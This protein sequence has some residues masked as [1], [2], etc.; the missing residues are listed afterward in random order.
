MVGETLCWFLGGGFSLFIP[1]LATVFTVS[2][3]NMCQVLPLLFYLF[4]CLYLCDDSGPA[5]VAFHYGYR[6]IKPELFGDGIL[7]KAKLWGSL[8]LLAQNSDYQ[9]WS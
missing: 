5:T 9:G 6:W 8:V 7:Q 2:G 1:P 4:S 3:W